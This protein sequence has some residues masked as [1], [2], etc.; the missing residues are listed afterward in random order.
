[1]ISGGHLPPK[2]RK[3]NRPQSPSQQVKAWKLQAAGDKKSKAD[4]CKQKAREA[5]DE[6]FIISQDFRRFFLFECSIC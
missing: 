5:K 3:E 6:V 1:M 4:E 2:K